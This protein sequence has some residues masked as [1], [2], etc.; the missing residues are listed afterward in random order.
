M[1]YL[2][3]TLPTAAENLALDEALLEEAEAAGQPTETLRVWEPPAPVVVVGRSSR[4]EGEIH[5]DAC[6]ALDVEVLRRISGGASI[7]AG[8][9]CLMYALVLSYRLRPALRASDDAHRFV[10]G[11]LAAALEP[12]VPGVRCRGTSDLA[13]DRLKFSGN[14]VRCR[15]DHL[16][17]HGTLLYDFPLELIDRCLAMPPRQPPY[18]EGRKHADFVA[19][20]PL[21]SETIRR[22]LVAAWQ[23][24]EPLADWPRELMARLVARKYGR[25]EWNEGQPCPAARTTR[26]SAGTS[27]P[28]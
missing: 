22:A 5:R 6:R 23:A 18:R 16:L 11:R 14:S 17:Y 26:R 8:P 13:L 15:R 12:H 10:L 9:G 3:L 7:V 19:N 25:P 20:L 2:D 24:V 27:A 28:P 21:T 1:R 4:I